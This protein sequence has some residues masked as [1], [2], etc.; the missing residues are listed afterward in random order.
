MTRSEAGK[1]LSAKRITVNGMTIVSKDHHVDPPTDRIAMDGTT[2]FYDEFLY[3]M[4]NKP[5]GVLSAT[6]DPKHPTVIDAVKSEPWKE[7][8][9]AGRLDIDSTGLI[10][11][12]NDG[13]FIHALTKAGKDIEKEYK[14]DYRGSMSGENRLR[15]ASG[16]AIQ[17]GQGNIYQTRPCSIQTDESVEPHRAVVCLSEGKFH[18]VKRMFQHFGCE[19]IS[20]DRVRIGPFVLDESLERGSY[21]RFSIEE[22]TWV[23]KVK[24]VK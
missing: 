18:Q 16:I 17:D 19:V 23:E 3:I 1:V 24:R 11:L 9:I 2:I 5:V 7:L 22:R 15:F 4:M 10:V 21:R 12:T 6:K 20:L 8:S 14:V 13:N